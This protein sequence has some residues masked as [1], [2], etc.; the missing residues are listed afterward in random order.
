MHITVLIQFTVEQTRQALLDHDKRK[1]V[2]LSSILD[3]N[4]E[5]TE[6]VT[7]PNF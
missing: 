2:F 1:F 5:L 6:A 7:F 3:L 4:I